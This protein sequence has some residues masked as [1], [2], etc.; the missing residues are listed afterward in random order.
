MAKQANR[1]LTSVE[2]PQNDETSTIKYSTKQFQKYEP[3]DISATK[4]RPENYC[5]A[6]CYLSRNI[7]G[8]SSLPHTAY[9]YNYDTTTWRSGWWATSSLIQ[10]SISSHN[11]RKGLL[12]SYIKLA[13]KLTKKVW[14][15]EPNLSI[16]WTLGYFWF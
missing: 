11:S 16:L 15:P 2:M 1:V 6:T 8:Y 5:F 4:L 12:V 7:N 9:W 3:E 10:N 13:N 14:Y